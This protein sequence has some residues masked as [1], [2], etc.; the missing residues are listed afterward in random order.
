MHP[1]KSESK[2]NLPW[3][4]PR[5]VTDHPSCRGVWGCSGWPRCATICY[6]HVEMRLL[7][8]P[9]HWSTSA[10]FPCRQIDSSAFHTLHSWAHSHFLAG[11]KSAITSCDMWSR[12]KTPIARLLPAIQRKP[13]AR[14]WA[15][16]W[17]KKPST[18]LLVVRTNI[19]AT[20][21]IAPFSYFLISKEVLEKIPQDFSST[22]P[23][24]IPVKEE[25][26]LTEC[27]LL[28][29]LAIFFT[30]VLPIQI[31]KIDDTM[32]SRLSQT[33]NDDRLLLGVSLCLVWEKLSSY[34][35]IMILLVLPAVDVV[36]TTTVS[37]V[38][39]L[40]TAGPAGFKLS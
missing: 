31:S 21:G 11:F 3:R 13:V 15:W 37:E 34:T 35:I 6:Q 22:I 27:I 39:W 23:V 26:F 18:C 24:K 30:F 28:A 12:Y 33:W 36:V 16:A 20:F 1:A 8:L 14:A 19:P 32:R 9:V 7:N 4:V 10:P 38:M 29:V 40:F 5:S 25:G 17:I 2:G